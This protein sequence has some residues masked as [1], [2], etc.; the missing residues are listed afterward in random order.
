MAPSRNETILVVED[1]A[2]LRLILCESLRRAGYRVLEAGDGEEA[3]DVAARHDGDIH[4][5]LCDLVLPRMNGVVLAERLAARQPKVRTVYMSGHDADAISRYGLC[6]DEVRYLGKPFTAATLVR[7]L[8][9]ALE[10]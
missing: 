6:V 5:L 8:R 10:A 4:L 7:C 1:A 2:S 9:E 3:L